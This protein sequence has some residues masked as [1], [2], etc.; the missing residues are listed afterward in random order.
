MNII[1]F[2]PSHVL[3]FNPHAGQIESV[4]MIS[5]DRASVLAES[6]PAF[7]GVDGYDVIGCGGIA[8]VWEG[9]YVLW[10]LLSED[11]GKHMVKITK[12]AQRLL[13]LFTG[14]IEVVVRSDFALGHRWAAI[15][16]FRHHHHEEKY[17]PGGL[18][19]DVYM[20]FQ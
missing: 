2:D 20:R 9:R 4:G 18:D 1:T 11:S 14:R 3:Q 6:G 19:A 8:E 15:L 17:F 5:V 12:M 16:G 13:M 10:A 7:T